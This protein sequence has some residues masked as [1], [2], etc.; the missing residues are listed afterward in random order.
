[1]PTSLALFKFV[2]KAALNYVGFGVG[3]DFAVEVL[4]EIA[5][6][7]W[8]W[9]GKDRSPE[10]LRQELQEVAQ[11]PAAE[12]ASQAGRAV[13]EEA[14]QRPE[15]ERAA[16]TAYL[17]LIPAAI[18]Q[19]QRRLS[20]PTGRTMSLG[21]SLM[22]PDDMLIVLPPRL[23][24]FKPSDRP[25][26]IGDWELVEL[27]GAGGFGE[28]WK[29]RNPYFDGVPPVALK[30]CLDPASKDRLLRHEAAVLNQVMRQGRHPGIVPLQHTYL[31]A[32]P[33]C[34]EYEFVEGGDLGTI[35]R[36]A[37]PGGGLPPRQA[38]RIIEE[39][40]GAVGFAHRLTPPIVHRDLKP[41][42]ILVQRSGDG[43][44]AFRVADFGIGGVAAAQA[45]GQTRLGGTRG[46]LLVSSL[47]GSY[48]P[49]YASPQ[50]VQGDP[51]DPRDDVYSLGVIWYQLLTGWVLTGRPGGSAWKKRLAEKG[52]P[53]TLIDLLEECIEERPADRPANASVLAERITAIIKLPISPPPSPPAP[54]TSPPPE[55]EQDMKDALEELRTKG[56]NRTYFER[57]GPSRIGA[58][59]PAAENGDA[60]A[61][62]LL[63]RCLQEGTG[64]QRD[65]YAAVSWLRRA[66]ESGLAIAQNDLGN[67]YYL[68]EGVAADLTEAFRLYTKAAEQGFME[69]RI[70]VG[71]CYYEGSG[72][73]KAPT[74]AA[75]CYRQ[76]ADAGWARGQDSL[77]DCYYDGKGVEQDYPQAIGWY[78]KAAEQGLASAQYNLGWCYGNGRGVKKN[79][80]E[81][82]KWYRLAAE[83][84]NEN[85][86]FA[87]GNCYENGYG[88]EAN[89]A[90]AE[91]W[92]RKAAD[93]GH[94]KSKNAL[95]RLHEV[96]EDNDVPG[97]DD[98][99]D[100]VESTGYWVIA[101]YFA[102]SPEE[103]QQVWEF[104]LANNIISIGW[105]GLGDISSLDEEE[106]RAAI[107]HAHPDPDTS[108]QARGQFFG[109]LWN[110]FHQIKVGDVVIAR[111]GRKKLAAVGTVIR[112]A[113]FD[114]NKT[115]SAVGDWFTY[116]NHLDV[117]WGDYPRD[118]KFDDQV[119]GMQTVYQ[120]SEEKF[121][122][123]IGKDKPIRESWLKSMRLLLEKGA[124][125]PDSAVK[126]STFR[127]E[128]KTA[129]G[130]MYGYDGLS[131]AGLIEWL[132]REDESGWFLYLTAAGRAALDA[133]S[134]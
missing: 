34:L 32:D 80:D 60:I 96:D 99:D 41:A 4:P 37:R 89:L 57:Q 73:E 64:T 17:S 134:D 118:K 77:G 56:N 31:S 20:D 107:D 117:E 14:A 27:L 46:Q 115:R 50:Q 40:A 123:L 125:S 24:R 62:W 48:T 22:K 28:V 81:A 110:F 18:R 7:V 12:A 26:G 43:K 119:F 132:K 11:L 44:L 5:R 106:L 124:I 70:N 108:A 97:T 85:A 84:G 91:Q 104:D 100:T 54:P 45:I 42:N 36:D 76:T 112:T 8:Q 121:C 30:F 72:V 133:K 10:Q 129:G 79:R 75:R 23:P 19:S 88:V 59:Q 95:R 29:A 49:L 94:K 6:D 87:L 16:L 35:I 74:E 52:T 101:P 78:R 13:A 66:A 83:H 105:E 82:V 122:T 109:M 58:W 25:P 92:Y 65:I 38:A 61:Q 128:A 1:M 33:P 39:L 63:A 114:P 51:P 103:W 131:G 86:Q 15:T 90:L 71:D 47:R 3:G 21:L 127:V 98:E 67:C 9:W 93:K 69:A 2:A 120:I 55:F 68:G 126:F 130:I 53:T 113:Y 102:A 116:G 111:R